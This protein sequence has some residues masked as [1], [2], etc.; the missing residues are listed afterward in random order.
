MEVTLLIMEKS[1]NCVFEFLLLYF[2]EKFN[3]VQS[4][5][6]TQCMANLCL[7]ELSWNFKLFK[8]REFVL[9]QGN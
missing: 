9:C 3:A 4:L 1:W 6:F 5:G 8:V 7:M 2:V